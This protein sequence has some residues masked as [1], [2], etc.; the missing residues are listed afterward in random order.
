MS[1]SILRQQPQSAQDFIEENF[2]KWR[3]D[4]A[5]EDVAD[6]FFEV[7]LEVELGWRLLVGVGR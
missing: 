7:R 3:F 2:Y 6:D 1:K 5:A 4:W